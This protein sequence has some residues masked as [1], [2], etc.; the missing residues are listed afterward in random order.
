MKAVLNVILYLG[1]VLLLVGISM[2][3]YGISMF[4]ARGEFSALEIDLGE[5]SF[6]FWM[7]TIFVGL[8]M[9]VTSLVIKYVKRQY[10]SK[11]ALTQ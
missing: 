8:I 11:D 2:F 7:P 6:V 10:S 5:L 3:F 4:T 9:T 1:S